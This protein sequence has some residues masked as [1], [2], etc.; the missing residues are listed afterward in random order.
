MKY[1]EEIE[2]VIGILPA[3]IGVFLSK[4]LRYAEAGENG[5]AYIHFIGA[6][7]M[8]INPILKE[9]KVTFGCKIN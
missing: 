7:E 3:N 5:L 9:S 4:G 8:A 2:K 6:I 1:R